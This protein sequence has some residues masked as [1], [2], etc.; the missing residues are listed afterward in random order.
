MQVEMDATRNGFGAAVAKLGADNR[1]IAFGADIT[2]SIRMDMFYKEAPE[3]KPR[4]F[5][6]GIAEQNMALVAAGLAKEGFIPFI[7]SYGVFATGRNWD[8]LRTTVAYN[9]YCVKIADAHGGISVGPDGATHQ[10]LEEISL[11]AILPGFHMT[12]PA[13]S[14]ETA[15]CT[16]VIAAHDGPG[17]VRYAR[18][19]TPV[20]T[21]EDTPFEFGAANVIRFRGEQPDFVDAFET[22]LARDYQSEHE[23]IAIIAC[24]PMVPEA[25]RAAYILKQ[26]LDLDKNSTEATLTACLL[27][28]DEVS[29]TD[30]VRI[31]PSKK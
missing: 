30:G 19:P 1:V 27:N 22:T 8:Q 14:V 13:D 24:G 15:K 21:K 9:N 2:S 11:I 3:R 16:E 20:V 10:A 7:G 17:V 5:S 31:V 29:G 12:V 23:D 25:M 4:F 26:E 18:E 6:V 28:G